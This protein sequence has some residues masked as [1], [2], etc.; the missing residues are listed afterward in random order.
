MKTI[1][2]ILLFYPCAILCAQIVNIPDPNFKNALLG[3]GVDTN[4]DGNIQTSEAEN[5]T[6]PMFVGSHNIS[7]L[8]GIESFVNITWLQCGLNNLT[9]LDLS[10]NTLLEK[11]ECYANPLTSIDLSNNVNLQTLISWNTQL[12]NLDLSLNTA[13][14]VI[15]LN[16]TPHTELDISALTMLQDISLYNCP[17]ETIDV[18]NN[19]NLLNL[20]CI[21]TDISE[22]D[23]TSNPLLEKLNI[24]GTDVNNVDLTN[25]PNLKILQVRQLGFS[26]LDLSVND[27]L[28]FLDLSS[29]ALTEF[30]PS[31]FL[32]LQ[33]LRIRDNN[34]TSIDLSNNPMLCHLLAD[35]DAIQNINIKNGQNELF[36]Q[37]GTCWVET[38]IGGIGFLHIFS[39]T[40]SPILEFICV[41]DIQFA[42]E[43]FI[44]VPS[45]VVFI[46][47]CDLGLEDVSAPTIKL[48]P[49][50]I[51]NVVV[52]QSNVFIRELE[53]FSTMGQ[54][55]KKVPIHGF[56]K[57]V[58]LNNLAPG[59]YF[60][61]VFT[62]WT[63]V[64]QKLVKK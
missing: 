62:E 33:G 40:D 50:P 1:L 51:D 15:D 21:Q 59:T 9:T 61:K 63:N 14:K 7:D 22:I 36:T 12:S 43:N 24:S 53:V 52:L 38:T 44:N 25:N 28:R 2:W 11:L 3:I 48:Y 35:S 45:Q 54:S 30:D 58:D 42:E 20:D 26:S 49:N 32:D 47:N 55:I 8:T 18:S 46:D 4:G 60:V 19:P 16:G 57:N 64:V 34:I 56:D 10:A 13:L 17:L 5:F 39:V 41:D 6:N 27:K 31:I 29:N 37:A 23:V